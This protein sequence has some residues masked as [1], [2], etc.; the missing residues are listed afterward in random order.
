MIQQDT[1]AK[2][3]WNKL[4]DKDHVGYLFILPAVF[5]ITIFIIIPLIAAFFIGLLNLDSFM[6]KFEFVGFDNFIRTVTDERVWNA[7]KNTLVYVAI[8]VP[9]Q[10][11]AALLLAFL[12]YRPTFFNKLCRSI[13][14]VPV[15][16]SFVAI[17]ILFNIILNP[18]VG[19]IPY[20]L[21]LFGGEPT[22]LLSDPK[23]A[24]AVVIFISV[25]KIFGKSMIIY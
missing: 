2:R 25:W 13:F 9:I 4:T 21:T 11:G 6:Q 16:C 20:I 3:F 7:F 18:T 22:A 23:Y 10:L 1:C 12:L 24:M 17:G 5:I 19:H 15:L 14:Y 8:S